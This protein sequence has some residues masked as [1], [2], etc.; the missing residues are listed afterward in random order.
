MSETLSIRFSK[1]SDRAGIIGLYPRAFPNDELVSLVDGLLKLPEEVSSLVGIIDS[2][3]VGHLAFTKVGENVL[4]LGPLAIDPDCQ[5]RGW[6]S[7]MVQE[8]L[9]LYTEKGVTKVYVL[10]DPNF[11][12]RFGFGKETIVDTPYSL[13]S[14]WEGAWQSILL[15]DQS[16]PVA[17]IDLPDIWMQK[18]LWSA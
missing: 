8:G 14:E 11:Y 2:K 4:L 1:P 13:P 9:L 5:R 3:I 10:G 7:Q 17:S 12:Q 15:Q 18:E 16:E 6:G